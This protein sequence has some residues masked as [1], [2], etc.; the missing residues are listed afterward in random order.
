MPDYK[1][2]NIIFSD[3][4]LPNE[5]TID[6]YMPYLSEENMAVE[7]DEKEAYRDILKNNKFDFFANS[8]FI[9]VS[10]NKIDTKI[11]LSKQELIKIDSSMKKFY[12][13]HYGIESCENNVKKIIGLQEENNKLKQELNSI[14][15]S[16]SWKITKPIRDFRTKNT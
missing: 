8:F 14:V 4:Y 6:A 1:L 5:Q 15:N 12:D 2:P 11:D 10:E 3:E 16:K 9:E 7:Y 13:N